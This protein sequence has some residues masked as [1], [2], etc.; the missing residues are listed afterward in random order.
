MKS[1][2]ISILFAVLCI[3]PCAGADIIPTDRTEILLDE[4]LRKLDSTAVYAAGRERNIQELQ[5]VLPASSSLESYH[6]YRELVR[7]YSNYVADSAFYYLGEAIAVAADIG[8]DSLK[9][10]AELELVEKLSDS[11]YTA[12]AME[13][14]NDVQRNRLDK[15]AMVGY[16][17]AMASMYHSLYSSLREP[18]SFKKRYRSLY[19]VYRDSLLS[20][21]DPMSDL[22]LRNM[23]K[24]EARAGNF[25][26]A[27]ECNAI[28]M[29]RIQDPRSGAMATCIY[30]RFAIAYN[31]EHNVTGEA[32]DDLLESAII[33]VEQGNNNIAS[34]LR[35][36]EYLFG[37]NRVKDAKKV[38]DYYFS[39]LQKFGSRKR[40]LEVIGKTI[41]INERDS[42]L[43]QK[44]KNEL[45]IAL[46]FISMLLFSIILML[47]YINS[48]RLEIARLNDNLRHSGEI[49]RSYI[50]LVFQ[51]NSSHIKRF[52]VFRTKVHSNLKKNNVE[53]ALVLTSPMNDIAGEELKELYSNFDSFFVGIY[54]DYISTVNSCLKPQMKIVPKKTEILTTELRILALIKLGITDSPEIAKMLHCSVKTVYNLRS[55]LKSR[56]AVTPE[57]FESVI[58]AL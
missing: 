44:N 19:N 18:E 46:A 8:N 11:G 48:K 24:K 32:I 13:V 34:L 4:L 16:Y 41:E 25:A 29:S 58:D 53:Q 42:R 55:G 47:I 12:E 6:L 15:D 51:L 21:A 2:L 5:S 17:R 52:D 49:M 20:V 40:L 38:S 31:Y 36:E 1:R 14:I 30:D 28:R 26:A 3:F 7:M 33:E 10:V 23:E 22:Y 9:L 57:Q 50:G 43:L 45:L 27:R 39:T 56:L 54:P 37:I 35:V